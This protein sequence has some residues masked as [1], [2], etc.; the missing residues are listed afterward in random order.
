M[1]GCILKI[2]DSIICKRDKGCKENG[3]AML[4]KRKK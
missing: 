1:L 2:A 4:W 3:G